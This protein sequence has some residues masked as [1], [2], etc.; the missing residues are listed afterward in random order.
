[1]HLLLLAFARSPDTTE[2]LLQT[3]LLNASTEWVLRMRAD[4]AGAYVIEHI[5]H[6]PTMS[7]IAKGLSR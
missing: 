6:Y 3:N 4:T 2:K 5:N 7:C 1:M